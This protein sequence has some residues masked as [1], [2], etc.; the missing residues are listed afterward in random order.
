M[1]G[2]NNVIYFKDME[3][4]WRIFSGFKIFRVFNV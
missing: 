1:V 2:S 4:R 3:R